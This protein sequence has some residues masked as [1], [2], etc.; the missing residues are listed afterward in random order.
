MRVNKGDVVEGNIS[1]FQDTL[2]GRRLVCQ[3]SIIGKVVER[4][5]INTPKGDVELI[6]IENGCI[7][8]TCVPTD[9]VRKLSDLERSLIEL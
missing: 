5:T 6:N 7:R 4:W 2:Y 8:Y 9:I 1:S 3:T